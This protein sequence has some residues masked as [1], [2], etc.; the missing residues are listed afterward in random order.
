MSSQGGQVDVATIDPVQKCKRDVEGLPQAVC[1]IGT[2]TVALGSWA[3]AV[4]QMP[5]RIRPHQPDL[6]GR[7]GAPGAWAAD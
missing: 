6:G 1:G 3:G 2:V 4:Q 5:L 7:S